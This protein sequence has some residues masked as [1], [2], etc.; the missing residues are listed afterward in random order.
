MEAICLSFIFSYAGRPGYQRHSKKYSM[1]IYLPCFCYVGSSCIVPLILL[2]VHV[3]VG[4]GYARRWPDE[5]T[6]KGEEH[7]RVLPEMD[8]GSGFNGIS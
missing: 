3:L 4:K 2:H 6:V 5:D 1:Y 8:H 7:G